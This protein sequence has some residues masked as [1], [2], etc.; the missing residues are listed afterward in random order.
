MKAKTYL[1]Q[2]YRLNIEIDSKLEQLEQLRELSVR[3]KSAFIGERI[4]VTKDKSPM[5]SSIIKVVMAEDEINRLIDRF[6]DLKAEISESI[7]QL[8]G[9]ESRI[10]LELRYLC[11]NSWDEIVV[12]MNYQTS[13]IYKL[14]CKAL[15]ELEKTIN[16]TGGRNNEKSNRRPHSGQICRK[17]SAEA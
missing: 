13:Y 10:L 11:F 8:D 17:S 1:R 16:A 12:K 9:F 7:G 2:A 14:H 3:I 6:I 4:T 5:E 15:Q